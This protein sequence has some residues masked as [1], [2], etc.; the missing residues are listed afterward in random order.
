MICL[1]GCTG[2]QIRVEEEAAARTLYAEGDLTVLTAE[3]LRTAL[4]D[5]LAPGASVSLDTSSIT[6]IDLSGLQLLCSAHRT[7]RSQNG[8]FELKGRSKALLESARGSGYDD[9]SVCRFRSD[10]NCLWKGIT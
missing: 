6:A 4:L 8:V 7:F 2:L 5:L 3:T 1:T 10:G 9:H